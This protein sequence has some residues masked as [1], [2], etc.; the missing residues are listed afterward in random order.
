MERPN[1]KGYPAIGSR[2]SR[3]NE[4]VAIL[5]SH[6]SV[7]CSPDAAVEERAGAS[8]GVEVQPGWYE[9]LNLPILPLEPGGALPLGAAPQGGHW[10][11]VSARVRGLSV[12]EVEV[13]ARFF[14]PVSGDLLFAERR[15][16]EVAPAQDDPSFLEPALDQRGAI[17]HLPVC[18]RD[19]DLPIYGRELR[20]VLEVTGTTPERESGSA[21][22]TVT[23]A[24]TAG[25]VGQ[26][27]VCECECSTDYDP[28]KCY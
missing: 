9:T 3:R 15:V 27:A 24:C 2:M 13:R 23:P 5:L 21:E 16:G 4:I 18:P 12:A 14:D 28:G 19:D 6:T 22:I 7:A 20:L 8:A 1:G 10:A 11:F 17:V 25:T 26:I